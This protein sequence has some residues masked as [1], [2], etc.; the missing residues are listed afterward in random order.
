VQI[1]QNFWVFLK[2]PRAYCPPR[3]W[4]D[5]AHVFKNS[6]II[7]TYPHAEIQTLAYKKQECI[8][9]FL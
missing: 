2:L 1:N 5:I 4:N 9:A 6:H 8:N 7:V 3:S